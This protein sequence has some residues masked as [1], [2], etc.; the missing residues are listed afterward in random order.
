VVVG[1]VGEEAQYLNRK[2]GLIFFLRSAHK[3]TWPPR[4]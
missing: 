1:G 2:N 4:A 3:A